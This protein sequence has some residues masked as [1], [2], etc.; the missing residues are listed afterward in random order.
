[1]QP[2]LRL[3]SS[4]AQGL[5]STS[6][7]CPIYSRSL[8]R[9]AGSPSD[10]TVVLFEAHT[11]VI[12][13]GLGEAP[14]FAQG[15]TG[16]GGVGSEPRLFPCLSLGATAAEAQRLLG[17]G[18]CSH[19]CWAWWVQG[20]FMF[21]QKHWRAS[22]HWLGLNTK[23]SLGLAVGD[24]TDDAHDQQ[25]HTDASNCQ[26]SLLVQLLSLCRG[27]AGTEP[28]EMLVHNLPIPQ[29][30]APSAQD[31]S[32]SFHPFPLLAHRLPLPPF[33]LLLPPPLKPTPAQCT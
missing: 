14:Q 8:Q 25:G 29:P 27:R 3:L 32:A 23:H 30:W 2:S 7:P 18:S 21:Q 17:T 1:M 13:I 6:T 12:I 28:M 10:A 4:M 9:E 33:R 5:S 20:G 16:D 26:D 31:L 22:P 15:P 19:S 11:R 24:H